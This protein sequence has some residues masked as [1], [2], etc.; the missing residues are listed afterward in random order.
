MILPENVVSRAINDKQ[1]PD[2]A[3]DYIYG[4]ANIAESGDFITGRLSY[5]DKFAYFI[6]DKRNGNT[7][8]YSSVTE[9]EPWQFAPLSFQCGDDV[10]LFCLHGSDG[11]VL[12]RDIFGT[13]TAPSGRNLRNYEI[14]CSEAEF[15]NP[16]VA[17]F[18]LKH[19]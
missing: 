6:Y 13:G 14:Y 1:L 10:S 18:Y 12:T 9:K 7:R 4:L 15:D 2:D 16:I 11:I 3:D 5:A 8:C 17:R 19:F